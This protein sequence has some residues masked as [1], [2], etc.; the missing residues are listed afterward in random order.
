MLVALIVV[1]R[2][3]CADRGNGNNAAIVEKLQEQEKHIDHTDIIVEGDH[4]R[5]DRDEG[6]VLGVNALLGI[7]LAVGALRGF[8]RGKASNG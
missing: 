7:L 1:P 2:P 4:S 5:L 3:A 6:I 8:N